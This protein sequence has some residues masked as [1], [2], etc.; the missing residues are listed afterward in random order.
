[1]VDHEVGF[2]TVTNLYM[3]KLVEN[4]QFQ[5]KILSKTKSQLQFFFLLFL[6][7]CGATIT[8]DPGTCHRP[9]RES[10]RSDSR[11]YGDRARGAMAW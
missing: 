2:L 8:L 9:R 3:Q 1:M 6:V 5:R 11:N 7:D 4:N 10:F